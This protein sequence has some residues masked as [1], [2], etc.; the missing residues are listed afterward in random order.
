MEQAGNA[1]GREDRD[2]A[3]RK[4]ERLA[5]GLKIPKCWLG[6]QDSN[7]DKQSKRLLYNIDFID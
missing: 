1:Q 4:S 2:G 5:K 6:K 3:G 7:L